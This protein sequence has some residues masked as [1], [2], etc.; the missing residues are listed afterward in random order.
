[1]YSDF[2]NRL[3]EEFKRE[4]PGEIA[5]EKMAPKV[6]RHFQSSAK[7]RNAGVLI[8]LFP[9]NNQLC[10]VCIKRTEYDGAHSGQI[11]FP[12]G[13]FEPGDGDLEQTALRES[14]EEIGINP[15]QVNILGQLTPLHIPVSNFYVVPFVGFYPKVP[16]FIRDPNEVEK[17]VEIPLVDLMNPKNCTQ[18]EFH[19]GDHAFTAPIYKSKELVI[20]G[21]TAMI[22]SEFLEV[23]KKINTG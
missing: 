7:R 23:V 12:G 15:K 5:Q 4:L 3:K 17:I 1:M 19:Y 9:K 8:L 2:F 22:M 21:A 16:E 6:R 13:K 11:S 18:Q 20:W 10:T 14:M